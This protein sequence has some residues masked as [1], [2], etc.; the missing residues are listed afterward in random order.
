[1]NASKNVEI[2]VELVGRK[3]T[4]GGIDELLG[5]DGLGEYLV[6]FDTSKEAEIDALRQAAEESVESARSRIAET[7]LSI[8]CSPGS[9]DGLWS[10]VLTGK[11]PYLEG[12]VRAT[13]WPLTV[14]QDFA[15]DIL[16]SDAHG[17]ISLGEF[18]ASS[19]TGLIAFELKTNHPDVSAR[20]VLNVPVTDVPEERNSVILQTVIS[21]KEG[22]LRYLLLLLWDDKISGLDPASGSGFAKWLARFVNNNP[23]VIHPNNR[24]VIH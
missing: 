17:E 11:I 6:D 21:N 8:K 14:T 2:L 7:T 20:F 9:K 22:F 13:A 16:D 12:I 1:M 10:L 23:I 4:V 15:V 19:V 3:N 5:A 24:K 18:S